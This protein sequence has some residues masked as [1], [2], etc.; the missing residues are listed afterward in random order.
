LRLIRAYLV[1]LGIMLAVA[2]LAS[3]LPSRRLARMTIM[4]VLRE[5]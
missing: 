3:V 2:T 1:A 5:E 4:N